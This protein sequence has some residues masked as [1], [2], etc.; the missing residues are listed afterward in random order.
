MHKDMLTLQNIG[1]NIKYIDT[2][3][4]IFALDKK[5][6]IPL[7]I[8]Y[9]FGNYLPVYDG[10]IQSYF[11]NAPKSYS[12]VYLDNNSNKLINVNKIRGLTLNTEINKDNIDHALF[13]EFYEQYLAEHDAKISI[14]QIRKKRDKSSRCY[15]KITTSTFTNT[16]STKRFFVVDHAKNIVLSYPYGYSSKQ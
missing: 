15:L 9:S 5:I 13:K 3:G 6:E 14:P 8:G 1:A 16:I 11:S 7:K 4:L 12:I 10:I 2:D